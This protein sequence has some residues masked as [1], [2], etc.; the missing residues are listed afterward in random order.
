LR[1]M[2]GFKVVLRGYDRRGVE[3]AIDRLKVGLR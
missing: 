1:P 3:E 2:K